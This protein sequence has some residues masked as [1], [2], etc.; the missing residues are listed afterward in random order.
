MRDP[1]F[2]RAAARS[3][4]SRRTLLGAATAAALGALS[5][6]G[7]AA[8]APGPWG[9][10]I[11]V[12]RAHSAALADDPLPSWND[13]PRKQAILDFV[14]AAT[15]QATTDFLPLPDRIATFDMDGTL[16]V[17]MPFYT[18]NAF[19]VA[20][21]Q[22]LSADHPD[23]RTTPPF[24][25]V[26]TSG[27]EALLT[28]NDQDW[29]AIMAASQVGLTMEEYANTVATWI[30]AAKHPRFDRLYTD[31]I[32]QPMLEVM[33]YLR[34]NDFR[35]YIVSGSGQEFMR[36]YAD[37][38]FGVAPEQVIGT[39]F[40]VSYEMGNDGAPVIRI[41][42]AP[43]TDDNFAGKPEDIALFIGRRPA[44]AFGNSTGDQ[45]MLE[46]AGAG[47]RAT[48]MMLV[49]HDDAAREYAYGPAGGLP[50][51]HVGTFTD[52]LMTEAK[53]RGWSVISM[54]DD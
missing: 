16:W 8:A 45:Q 37:Q 10:E 47:E 33:A 53:D 22:A 42:A 46:W 4:L 15:D 35:T 38:V 34:D 31:L 6:R 5:T 13:G 36:T 11:A 51:T 7:S 29:E 48:L 44:A 24:A 26:L 3:T 32:Y 39:T 17:E 50:D 14:A 1:K 18:E 12:T 41:D 25:K 30:A 43:L 52:A 23:W 54:K 49:Y 40:Q 28:L 20:R 2:A 27:G 9:F 21:L 19:L